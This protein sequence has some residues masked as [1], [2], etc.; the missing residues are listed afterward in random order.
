M[1]KHSPLAGLV[2]LDASSSDPPA[3]S[4]STAPPD[5]LGFVPTARMSPAKI[6]P[7]LLGPPAPE[8]HTVLADRYELHRRLGSGGYGSVYLALDRANG[9]FVALKMLRPDLTAR[10]AQLMRFRREFRAVARLDHPHCLRVFDEGVDNDRF[11]FTMELVDGGDLE[12]VGVVS[13]QSLLTILF[14]I[15]DALDYIH[16]RRLIHRDLKPANILLLKSSPYHIKL[17]DFGLARPVDQ[18]STVTQTGAVLGTIAF[19]PPEQIVG[20]SLDPRSDLYALGCIIHALSSG[21]TPF[22]DVGTPFQ[23]LQAHLNTPPPPLT[24]PNNEPTHPELARLTSALLA[25]NPLDRPQS[26][27]V[28]KQI[29]RDLLSNNPDSPRITLSSPYTP[30][31]DTNPPAQGQFLYRPEM[32]GRD[33]ERQKVLAFSERIRAKTPD[34]PILIGICALAGMGK[35]RLLSSISDDLRAQQWRVLKVSVQINHPEPFAPFA[36]LERQLDALSLLDTPTSQTIDSS[37][38]LPSTDPLSS[39]ASPE[40]IPGAQTD[41]TLARRLRAQSLVSRIINASSST[42]PIAI[43]FEDIHDLDPSCAALLIDLL[44]SLDTFCAQHLASPWPLLIA[45]LRPGDSRDN[46]SS[47]PISRSRP[48]SWIDLQPLSRSDIEHMLAVMIGSSPDVV[49]ANLTDQV[50]Q[51]TEGNPLFVQAYVQAMIDRGVLHRDPLGSWS[52]SDDLRVISASVELPDAMARI[53]RDRLQL[54][55]PNTLKLMRTAAL[56]GRRFDS[57]L[58]QE[59]SSSPQNALLDSIDEALRAW[60]IQSVKGPIHL[61]LYEFD[62]ARLVDVLLSD[63]SPSR[64][65]A[66]HD[67]IALALRNRPDTPPSILASHLQHSSSPLDAIPFL[68]AAASQASQASDHPAALSFLQAAL[69]LSPNPP[70]DLLELTADTLT[71]LGRPALAHALLQR[72]LSDHNP[73][74]PVRARLLYKLARTLYFSGQTTTA[75]STYNLTLLS[76]G[77]SAALHHT[78]LLI[79]K[80]L[81]ISLFRPIILLW[82]SL[83]GGLSPEQKQHLH[84]RTLCHSDL[85][86]FFYWT[87]IEICAFHQLCFFHF[88]RI[89]KEPDLLANANASLGLLL[90]MFFSQSKSDRVFSRAHSIAQSSNLTASSS[91]ILCLQG[92]A[93]TYGAHFSQAK[94]L[95]DN[96]LSSAKAQGDRFHTGFTQIVNGWC[97]SLCNRLLDSWDHFSLARDL[98]S[99]LNDQ[100]LLCDAIIGRASIAL[101][102]GRHDNLWAETDHILS[103]SQQFNLPAFSALAEELRGGFHLLNNDYANASKHFY[104]AEH[105]YQQH[106]LLAAWGFLVHPHHAEALL[107]LHDSPESTPTLI[108]ALRSL[109]KNGNIALRRPVFAGFLDCLKA[110]IQSRL[111][112]RDRAISLFNKAISAS[113]FSS[114]SLNHASHIFHAMILQR[115]AIERARLGDSSSITSP[116]FDKAIKIFDHSHALGIRDWVSSTKS[117]FS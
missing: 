66:S 91:R 115:S 77:S 78:R 88:A 50:L 89:L 3:S 5:D 62:H 108:S 85:Y 9:A 109:V 27:S 105:T 100:R 75:F 26:A 53:L 35:S 37:H 102:M 47:L 56:I 4:P 63:L 80:Q 57:A 74:N 49:R 19:M 67:A 110:C 93:A 40:N 65:R 32:V 44:R 7:Q 39:A 98:A 84:I 70:L 106:K 92:I 68:R 22:E 20:Q 2:R 17:A 43:I 6:S 107:S 111:G 72:T 18:G 104:L 116:I 59:A 8:Q 96:A 71:T 11:F 90:S 36:D 112:H 12:S 31:L 55:S 30:G 34:A 16:S 14:Q 23:I 10:P 82:I 29:L 103:I 45:S 113:A 64:K 58:L 52:L 24:H 1:D 94:E 13:E 38:T 48:I 76:L 54:L 81:F 99:E 41:P 15:T 114:N 46:L 101:Y 86:M 73:P 21:K 51:N 83:K 69:D 117:R 60:I 95:L 97:S 61:D 25:K 79:A 87:N 33:K 42:A 28:V